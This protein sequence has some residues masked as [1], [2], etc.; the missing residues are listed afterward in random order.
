MKNDKDLDNILKMIIDDSYL[1]NL[2]LSSVVI[3]MNVLF[4]TPMTFYC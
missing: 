3:Y 2:Y 4:K 1:G